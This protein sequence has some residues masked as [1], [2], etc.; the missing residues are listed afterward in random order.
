MKGVNASVGF[1]FILLLVDVIGIAIIIP[2]LPQL[3][4]ELTGAS[5]SNAAVEGGWLLVA[6]SG[7]QFLFAPMMGA[8][9]DHFGRKPVLVL[10]TLGLGLDFLLMAFAPTL[11]W[12]FIGRIIAG[13]MGASFSTGAA[14]IADVSA[15]EKRA[16]NFGLVGV[17]FATSSAVQLTQAI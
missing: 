15:P 4:E 10:S 7:M 8:L 12:L 17:T 5:I 16:Q 9:G 1:I 6:Y 14:Y 3:I 2:V 11:T 13:I